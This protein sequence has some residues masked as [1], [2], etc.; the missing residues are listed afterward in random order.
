MSGE[1]SS[2]EGSGGE[3]SSV[4]R[5]NR[6]GS[7]LQII[8]DHPPVNALAQPV[9]AG[10]LAA[11]TAAEADPEVTAI[12]ISAAGRSF[13]VGAD[14]HEFGKPAQAPLL[15]EVCN[16]IEACRKP[17]VAAL[18][19]T[20]LGGGLE[21]ALAAH[22]R[23]ALADAKLGLPEVGL[24]ILPGAGGTQRLPRLIGA[25]QALRLMLQGVPVP[26]AEALALGMLDQVVETDLMAAALAQ[27]AAPSRPTRDRREGM[28][29]PQAYQAAINAARAGLRGTRQPA[30]PR[31]VDC[32]EAA[33]LLPFDQG[34]AFERA[35]FDDLVAS[36]EAAAL[37]HAFFAERALARLPEA[38]LPPRPLRHLAVVGADAANPA[39]LLAQAGHAV[40]LLAPTKSGL[41]TALEVIAAQMQM[42][43]AAGSL[44]AKARDADWARITPAV[45]PEALA[46]ADLLLLTDATAL[47]I[48]LA[49]AK[50]GA[51]LVS[52]G[53]FGV[54]TGARAAD[55]LR[56]TLPQ[57][58]GR[59]AEV[60]VA[61]ATAPEAVAT[62]LALLRS[63]GLATLRAMAPGGL[64][65]RLMA[66]QRA[67]VA[68][69]LG[70]GPTRA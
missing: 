49:A 9:R 62:V 25:E 70:G 33:Q 68:H 40:T 55:M 2:G 35:A 26:A 60:I 14:I 6:I 28:R 17:V 47:E 48:G 21:L 37:R 41:V 13:P 34:L 36:P 19:G 44:T 15:A 65:A 16:R 27:G 20:A 18:H 51:V 66:A 22:L 5:Q 23:L 45:Q 7:V 54:S 31:I 61:E 63:L 57:P 56:L 43:V 50:P 30:P 4:V 10:L 3:V 67:A 32:V 58:G 53:G 42:A 52:L 46:D 69:L 38:K 39:L 1:V 24:G 8:I 11:L 29:D 12:V 64:G 59:L